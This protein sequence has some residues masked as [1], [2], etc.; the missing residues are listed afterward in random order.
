MATSSSDELLKDYPYDPTTT[1]AGITEEAEPTLS[2]QPKRF[3][4][5]LFIV[6]IIMIFASMTS[7]YIVR[8]AEGNWLDFEL[9]GILWASTAVL[10]VSSFTV[11]MA[12]LAAKKDELTAVRV[13]MLV[14]LALGLAFLYLQWESWVRLVQ[15]N[16]YLVGNPSGSFLYVLTGLHAFHLIT[17]LVFVSITTG[18]AFRYQ[19]HS[20]SM[21]NIEMCATYWHFL[22]ILWVALFG[23][24]VWNHS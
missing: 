5:W 17:G 7:A 13:W 4:L 15:I 12:Y 6:S 24:L 22:D 11:Q 14:T 2:M 16:V 19:V 8:Q 1:L 23:F 3:A 18:K 9:P 21:L 10:I 20:R